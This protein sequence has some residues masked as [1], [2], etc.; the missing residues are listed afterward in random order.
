[1][2]ESHFN[3][4]VIW[5]FSKDQSVQ[6]YS[7]LCNLSRTTRRIKTCNTRSRCFSYYSQVIAYWNVFLYI[8]FSLHSFGYLL[9]LWVW[10]RKNYLLVLSRHLGIKLPD[11]WSCWN[12]A[13]IMRLSSCIFLYCSHSLV[14]LR[15]KMHWI[16]Y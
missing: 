5:I 8:Y 6:S 3:S 16:R 1:M 14:L 13:P 15:F 2:S 12:E 11:F 10:F 7:F 9:R 4:T